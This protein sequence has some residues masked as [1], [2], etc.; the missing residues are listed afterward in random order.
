[1]NI[2]LTKLVTGLEKEIVINDK[3]SIPKEYLNN[4]E[5]RDISDVKIEGII[6]PHDNNN[7]EINL[8]IKCNLVLPCSISLKDVDYKLDF[9]LNEII[10]ENDENL[11]ENNKIINN[12]IDL[13]PIIWQNIILEV[14]LKVISPDITPKNIE[15]DG[16]RFV[17]DEEDI[18][19]DI[20]PRLE[21]LRKFLDE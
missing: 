1:M 17:T 4:T 15:G 5:I 7:F 2:N 18:K 21:D 14:P 3:V 10:G 6:F 13:I 11:E 12:T 8:N 9:D 20:D 16:W 19:K